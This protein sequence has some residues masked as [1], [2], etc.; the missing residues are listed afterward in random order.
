MAFRPF[1]LGVSGLVGKAVALLMGKWLRTDGEFR[2]FFWRQLIRA[3]HSSGY[4]A[5]VHLEGSGM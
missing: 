1:G 5:R 3:D 4:I 2:D